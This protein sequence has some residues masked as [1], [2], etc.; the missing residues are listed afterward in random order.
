LFGFKFQLGYG[1][2]FLCPNLDM[3]AHKSSIG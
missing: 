1:T 2:H 3:L